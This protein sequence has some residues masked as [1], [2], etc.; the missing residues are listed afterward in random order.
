MKKVNYNKIACIIAIIPLFNNLLSSVGIS[1]LVL[2]IVLI[3]FDLNDILTLFFKKSA[4]A[5][6]VLAVIFQVCLMIT[7]VL[8]L[9]KIKSKKV[10]L[11][12]LFNMIIMGLSILMIVLFLCLPIGGW[13]SIFKFVYFSVLL[14]ISTIISIIRSRYSEIDENL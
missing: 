12:D 2:Y 10:L 3:I 4:D 7:L 8:T 9:L 1:I 14:V 6:I 13:L 11:Y 5:F